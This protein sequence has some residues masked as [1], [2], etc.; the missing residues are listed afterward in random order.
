MEAYPEM[1]HDEPTDEN[2][3]LYEH[4]RIVVDKRQS[5][6][7]IDKFLLNR[8]E[9]ISRN[10]IQQTAKAGNILVNDQ[11]VKSNY[12]VKP[13]DVITAVFSYPPREVEIVPQAI[14]LD[15]IYEDDSILVLNKQPNLVVHPGHGN[16]SG[17]LLHALAYHFQTSPYY[18]PENGCGYLVHRI[19][20]DT[21]GL[22]VIAKDEISQAKLARQFFERTVERTY[23][24]IAW[25]VPE[26]AN[27]TITGHIGR[28]TKDR[29]M[30]AVYPDGSYGKEAITHYSLLE[31]HG[32]ISLLEC[33]LQTGRTHQIRV[34][35][36][37]IGHPLF[38]DAWYGGNTIVKGTIFSSYRQFIDN[39]FKLIQR[40][41]LHA[42][43]LGFIHPVTQQE[44]YFDSELPED[45]QQVL[46]KWKT[47]TGNRD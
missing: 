33:R 32:Y 45:M 40:Q 36:K 29:K 37:Y 43:S 39:C 3:E 6:L 8:L 42:K 27:G 7:R 17:T 41:A 5:T 11:A 30:M 23:Q 34:H 26:P 15:I 44:L 47:Y 21:T 1:L 14:P 28:S 16:F 19:D 25:G 2:S 12:K 20:K 10:K 46:Q 35:C 13:E 24:A 18:I 31:N 22:M 4:F 38:N 9:N